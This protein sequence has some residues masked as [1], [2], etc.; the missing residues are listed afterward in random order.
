MFGNFFFSFLRLGFLAGFLPLR[1]RF[2][3]FI[4]RPATRHETFGPI[5]SLVIRLRV[6]TLL[7]LAEAVFALIEAGNR[8]VVYTVAALQLQPLN[9]NLRPENIK[10]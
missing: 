1:L 5:L 2:F 6:I 3:R 10:L 8:T 4:F 9:V 7:L